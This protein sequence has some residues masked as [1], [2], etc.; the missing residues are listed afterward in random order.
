MSE[1]CA[2]IEEKSRKKRDE[3]KLSDKRAATRENGRQQA[4][5]L[6]LSTS[7]L[8]KTEIEVAKG[9]ERERKKREEIA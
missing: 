4:Q 3:N 6:H 5:T 1:A 8:C 2:G 7:R 9:R